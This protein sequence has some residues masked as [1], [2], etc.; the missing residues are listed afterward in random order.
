MSEGGAQVF[1]NNRTNSFGS[2]ELQLST[3]GSDGVG[4]DGELK[5]LFRID[6]NLHPLQHLH[7]LVSEFEAGVAVFCA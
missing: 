4:G 3:G 5:L 2:L 7:I 6:P 1:F